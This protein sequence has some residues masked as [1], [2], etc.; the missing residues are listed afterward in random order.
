MA[1]K[2][3]ATSRDRGSKSGRL[4]NRPTRRACLQDLGRPAD[5]AGDP[6]S[7][8]NRGWAYAEFGGIS[9]PRQMPGGGAKIRNP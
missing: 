5:A 8:D 9:S 4:G 2:G 3:E 6:I 7:G 1:R